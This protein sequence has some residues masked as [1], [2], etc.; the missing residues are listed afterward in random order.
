MNRYKTLLC[1]MAVSVFVGGCASHPTTVFDVKVFEAKP[2]DRTYRD[3][4]DRYLT[5]ILRLINTNDPG[6]VCTAH[7]LYY[8][9]KSVM[10]DPPGSFQIIKPEEH[11]KLAALI[12]EKA[13]SIS[14]DTAEYYEKCSRNLLGG[15]AEQP[16]PAPEAP[17]SV[18]R[19]DAMRHIETSLIL[20]NQH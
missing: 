13:R 4:E 5:I 11:G 8:A 3:H 10:N 15:K 14:P 7:L 19:P 9:C 17:K 18:P 20:C 6:E 2:T 12:A 1:A 16:T